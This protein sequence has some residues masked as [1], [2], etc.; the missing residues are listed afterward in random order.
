M[1]K[2]SWIGL[3]VIALLAVITGTYTITDN[4]Y[5]CSERGIVM[6]CARFSESELRC[7]P[8]LVTRTGYKD[9]SSGWEKVEGE[10]VLEEPE[11]IPIISTQKQ[12][13]GY[14]CS[15]LGCMPL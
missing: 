15:N 6:E 11:V 1:K 13:N 2:V 9:C 10:L 8:S 5:F 7:Y 12:S 4:T 3:S 14:I